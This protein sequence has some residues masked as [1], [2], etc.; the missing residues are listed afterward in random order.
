MSFERGTLS[1]NVTSRRDSRENEMEVNPL[2]FGTIAIE[3][4]IVKG[5]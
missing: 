5:P 2:D 1:A 4:R 3:F